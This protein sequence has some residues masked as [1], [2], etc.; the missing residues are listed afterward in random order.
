MA[1]HLSSRARVG[2]LLLLPLLVSIACQTSAG[3]PPPTTPATVAVGLPAASPTPPSPAS[4]TATPAAPAEPTVVFGSGPF[5]WPQPAA[6]LAELSGYTA[7]LSLS[8]DGTQAGQASKWSKTYV[9]VVSRAPAARLLTITK[10]GDASA[11]VLLAEADGAAYERRGQNACSAAAIT[12]PSLAEQFEPAGLLTGVIGAAP[13]GSETV[14]GVPAN[15]YTFDESG[16]GQLGLTQSTGELWVEAGGDYLV[17]YTLSA[18]A[19]ADYFGNDTA[20]TLTWDYELTGANQPVAITLP[21]DCPVGL[22][23][24]PLLPDATQVV[25]KPGLITY[26]SGSSLADAAAFYQKQLA[27]LGW[28]PGRQSTI[29]ASIVVLDFTQADKKLTLIISPAQSA[30]TVRIAMVR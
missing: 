13:A 4:A 8:F 17:K 28:E 6:G 2:G 12:T 29:S 14:N 9:M 11:G 20:G 22:I 26:S 16:L 5:N 21:Q 18:K 24:A 25:S 10:A 23:Q 3:G 27:D 1:Q 19:G 7:T 30:I 15:H